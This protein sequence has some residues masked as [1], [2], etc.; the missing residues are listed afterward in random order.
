MAKSNFVKAA[1]KNIYKIGKIREYVSE[2]GK[3]QG[4]QNQ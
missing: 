2:K 4:Q 1:Q 3:S